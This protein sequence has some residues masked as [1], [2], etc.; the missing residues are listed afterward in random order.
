MEKCN[1]IF[2]GIQ[3]CGDNRKTCSFTRIGAPRNQDVFREWRYSSM[4]SLTSALDGSEL[5]SSRLG[6]LYPQGRSLWYPL[7]R[8]LGG[9]QSRSWWG[10]EKNSQPL[11]G[12]E[13]PIIQP[14]AQR[15]TTEISRL[16][17]L[18]HSNRQL[19]TLIFIF[20]VHHYITSGVDIAWWNNLGN[21]QTAFE[22]QFSTSF[23]SLFRS[24]TCAAAITE[25]KWNENRST[26]W[27]TQWQYSLSIK[28][29]ISK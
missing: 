24:G 21:K 23:S 5:S 10:D 4:H 2:N 8:R 19:L 1:K 15:Y 17:F 12:L 18:S 16:Q 26:A 20:V 29:S 13:P 6:P 28:H 25:Q 22:S 3:N 9:L 27:I 11:P 7:G 14:V